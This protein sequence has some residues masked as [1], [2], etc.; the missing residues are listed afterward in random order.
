MVGHASGILTVTD[1]E[2]DRKISAGVNPGSRTG[3]ATIYY[4]V[5]KGTW[6]TYRIND[7]NPSATCT[8]GT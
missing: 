7:T 5:G 8:C 1:S 4:L 3:S 6:Q 2:T